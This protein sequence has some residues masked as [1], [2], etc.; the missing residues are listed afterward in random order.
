[1]EGRGAECQ[2]GDDL[3][4]VEEGAQSRRLEGLV[5]NHY[6]V[7]GTELKGEELVAPRA[8]YGFATDHGAACA[9]DKHVLAVGVGVGTASQLQIRFDPPVGPVQERVLVEYGPYRVHR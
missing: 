7:A 6:S 4:P 8:F 1:M 3:G 2:L 9:H 5:G